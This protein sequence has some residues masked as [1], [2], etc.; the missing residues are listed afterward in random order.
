MIV[1]IVL[2]YLTVYNCDTG[3]VLYESARQMPVFS[4]SGDRLEDCRQEGVSQ[5]DALTARYRKAY[6]HASTNVVCDGNVRPTQYDVED[7]SLATVCRRTTHGRFRE[8]WTPALTK[9]FPSLAPDCF[10]RVKAPSPRVGDPKG[11]VASLR[12]M[13]PNKDYY[14][15]RAEEWQS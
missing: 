2:L 15:V 1:K 3:A 13:S 9:S 10:G 6:P 5:A 12:C 8:L 14:R 11:V 7:G 4:V